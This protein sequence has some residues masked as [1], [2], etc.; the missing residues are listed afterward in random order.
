MISA[1]ASTGLFANAAGAGVSGLIAYPGYR[2]PEGFT[3]GGQIGYDYQFRPG[4][5]LV[6]GAEADA[7]YTD[8]GSRRGYAVASTGALRPGVLLF[9]PNGLS[10]LDYFGTVRGRLGYAFDRTLIYATGGFAYTSYPGRVLGTSTTSE[11]FLTGYAVGGGIAYALPTDTFL[12]PFKASAVVFKAEG[13]YVNLG[14]ST[15]DRAFARNAAAA[16]L[17]PTRPV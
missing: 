17:Q 2:S 10:N 11:N 12:N 13:L 5:S 8:F 1:P 3:G 14:Q 16:L 7:Q 4:S 6:V 9:N 15:G